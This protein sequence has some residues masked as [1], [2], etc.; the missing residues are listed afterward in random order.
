MMQKGKEC[1]GEVTSPLQPLLFEKSRKGRTG[2]FLPAR[3]FPDQDFSRMIPNTLRRSTEA[4]LPELTEPDLVRHFINLSKKNF[5]VDTHFYP[6]GSCT[7][8]YNPKI[9]ED[10]ASLDGFSWVHPLQPEEQV[11]GIL[12]IFYE[13]A[14]SLCQLIGMDE[15]SLQPAAGAHG[16]LLGMMLTRAYH[17]WRGEGKRNR[18]LVPDSS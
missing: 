4:D 10:V 7:M 3:Q 13:L 9:H 8:K 18:V 17:I 14:Q 5:S 6:L 2:V 15:F 11:Q 16:E 12:K 1:R